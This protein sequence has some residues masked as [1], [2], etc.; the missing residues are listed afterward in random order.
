[1]SRYPRVGSSSAAFYGAL[2]AVVA[3]A[4]AVG[5]AIAY[6]GHVQ[7]AGL[8]LDRGTPTQLHSLRMPQVHP[9]DYSTRF[10]VRSS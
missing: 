3:L 8:P 4:V 9:L 7:D 1:M 2:I 6:S 10:V 5:I